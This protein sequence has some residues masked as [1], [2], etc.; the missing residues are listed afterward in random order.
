M[1]SCFLGL[2]F[3]SLSLSL[4]HI[5]WNV[6]FLLHLM[7]KISPHLNTSMF[8]FK[9][10]CLQTWTNLILRNIYL[11][12][13]VWL[14]RIFFFVS[15]EICIC[16]NDFYSKEINHFKA[17]GQMMEHEI[18]RSRQLWV[19]RT[20][21]SIRIYWRKKHSWNSLLWMFVIFSH[22]KMFLPKKKHRKNIEQ[23]SFVLVHVICAL[24]SARH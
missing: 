7:N 24:R 18:K 2:L 16:K 6:F 5:I 1:N 10:C 8:S 11:M 21:F 17:V 23:M 12:S 3:L 4:S 14:L 20:E 9:V 19:Y 22:R 15:M 13:F